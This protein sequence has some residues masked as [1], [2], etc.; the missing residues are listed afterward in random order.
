MMLDHIARQIGIGLEIQLLQDA[1]T[2]VANALDLC[3]DASRDF[4]DT[5]FSVDRVG[6]RLYIGGQFKFGER[7]TP[8]S[9]APCEPGL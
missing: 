2:E 5:A 7:P 1:S 4:A 3:F 9:A 6:I 8:L